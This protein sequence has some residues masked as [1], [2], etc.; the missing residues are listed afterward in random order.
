M[1]KIQGSVTDQLRNFGTDVQNYI[2]TN[3]WTKEDLGD[4]KIKCT[5]SIFF[6]GITGDNTYSAQMFIGSQRPIFVGKNPSEKSTAMVRLFDDKWDFSYIKSQPLYRDESK[7]DPLTSF[8]DFYM[9][10][11][12]G[13]DYDSYDPLTGTPYFQKALNICNLAP[14][15][16]S[17]WDRSTAQYCRVSFVE[18]LLNSKYFPFREGMYVCHFKGLDLLATKPDVARKNII[19]FIQQTGD[20]K[21]DVNPRSQIVMAFFDAKYLELADIFKDSQ[22]DSVIQILTSVDPGHAVIYSKAKTQ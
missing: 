21:R 1:D 5:I 20:L 22:D 14:S 2:N 15:S 3:K 13:Y 10:L 4:Y 8:L 17:G 19:D 18:E 7:F 6:V 11:I 12:I 9:N 16:S